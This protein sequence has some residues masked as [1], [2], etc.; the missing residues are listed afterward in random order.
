MRWKLLDI[1]GNR[2]VTLDILV[3]DLIASEGRFVVTHLLEK[4]FLFVTLISMFIVINEFFVLTFKELYKNDIVYY[5][6]INDG[7]S[8]VVTG[9]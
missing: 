6:V 1:V 2:R 7:Y 4:S 3:V 9:V 5:F 8:L